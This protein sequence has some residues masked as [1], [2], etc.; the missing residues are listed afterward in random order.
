MY[1]LGKGGRPGKGAYSVEE[2]IDV[3]C[4]VMLSESRSG[5]EVG[6][7]SGGEKVEHV[8]TSDHE[9]RSDSSRSP[10]GGGEETWKN[11]AAFLRL[12]SKGDLP[13]YPIEEGGH[14]GSE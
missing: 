10:G 3:R 12:G 8:S 5:I 2:L 4:K 1:S 6:L 13:G 7:P 14:L 11:L 9:G